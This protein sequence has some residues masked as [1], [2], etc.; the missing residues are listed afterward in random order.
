MNTGD[1]VTARTLTTIEGADIAVAD[2]EELVHL[3]FRRFAGCPI[4]S[5]HMHAWRL[6][7]TNSPR[8]ESPMWWCFIPPPIVFAVTSPICPSP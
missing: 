6:G 7:T 2:V 1:T 8:P 4:C 3:Q 5:L